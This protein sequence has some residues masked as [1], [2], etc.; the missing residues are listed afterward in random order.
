[1]PV[2]VI[3]RCQFCDAKPDPATQR[4]LEAQIRELLHGEYLDALPGRWL[5]WFGAGPLGPTRYACAE[6]RGE[7]TAFVRVHYG[8]VGWQPW[9]MP[10]YATTRRTRDTE[11]AARLRERSSIP[12]WGG[13]M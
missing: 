9:K 12:R 4:S 10:P 7:L 13:R 1:M 3:F 2:R 8:S 5:V 6:H 11:K